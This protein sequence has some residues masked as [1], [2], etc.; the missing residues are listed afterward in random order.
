MAP[1]SSAATTSVQVALRI[2]PPTNQDSTSI[3]ARFQ[4]TVIHATSSTSVS[5]E[6]TSSTPAAGGAAAA[7]STAS[8]PGV[9]KQLFSFDQ[10]H[11][12]STTQH[13]LFTST[14]LPL[15]S[16]F[17]EGFNCTILAYGQTSSGKTF[18]MTGI[19]LD[20]NPS[21]PNNGMGI[22]PRAVSSIFAGARKLKEERGNTWNYSIKGSFIEIYNEDL[23]DLLSMDDGAGGRREVQIREDKDGHIIWGGLR[24][25]NVKNP[26]E[27]MT[28]IRKGTSIRRTNETDMNAQS[29]RSHAIFSLTLTQKKYSGSGAPPRSSSPLPPGG[30]SPSRLARPGSVYSGSGSGSTSGNRVGSPTFGRPATPSFA[31]AMGRGGGLRPSSALGHAGD[32]ASAGGDD[33]GGEWTTIVSKFHFVDLAGSER[34]KRTAAAGERIK[35]GISINSGLL[36]LGNVISALGDP[37]RAKS[38]TA[39]HI[40]YRDSKLTR[41]LQDSLGGNA[42]TLMIA[43]VSPAEWNTGETV[44]TLKYANRARNIKNRAVVNEKEDGWDDVEWLQGTVTRLRKEVKVLKS[45]GSISS[46]DDTAPVP[47]PVEG[48]GKKVLAQMTELQNN[49]EDLRAKF[50]ER[51]EEL[52]RLRRE[53]GEKHRGSSGAVSGTGK[54]EEIVGPVIEEYEKTIAAMEAELSLNRAAL[55]HTNEMVEEKEEELAAVT[56]RHTATELYVEE[57]RSRVAKLSEREASTEAYVRDLEEKMRAYD[58]TSISSS[59]SMSDLKREVA[60]YKEADTHS[61]KYIADLEVRLSRSDESVVSLQ[62]TVER[63]EKESEQRQEEVQI[64]QARLETLRQDGESWRSDLER[65]EAKVRELEIKMVEWEKKRQDAGDARVRLGTV[66]DEVA[67]ARRSFEIDLSTPGSSP[68]EYSESD[69]FSIAGPIL[70]GHSKG[71]SSIISSPDSPELPTTNPRLQQELIALQQTHNATLADLSSVTTKYRDA[72]REISDLA[73]QIQEAKLANTTGESVTDTTDSERA[74]ERP[75]VKRR[76]TSGRLRENSET[77]Y[78]TGGRRLFFRQAAST[79]SLHSRSLSQSQSLSQELSSARSRKHS[80]SSHGTASSHSPSNSH[81]ATMSPRPNL[82]ISLPNGIMNIAPAERSAVSLEKEIMRLQEVLKE[83]EAEISTLELS[84]LKATQT[85]SSASST[86]DRL[87]DL[88]LELLNGH[89]D[90]AAPESFLSPQTI[91]KFEHIRRSMQF[92]GENG[93]SPREHDSISASDSI[94]SDTDESLDRLNE[95]ML[96]MAQKESSHRE[97]V[98][99][100]TRELDQTRRSFEELTTLSRD[101]ALNMSTEVEALR[102]KHQ[103][104][105]RRLEEVQQRESELIETLSKVE[106]EHAAEVEEL[107]AYHSDAL[108]QKQEELEALLSRVKEEH[109]VALSILQDELAATS[110]ALEEALQSHEQAFGKLRQDHEE[111]LRSKLQEASDTLASVRREHESVLSK[112]N[113]AHAEALKQKDVDATASIQQTEEDYYNALTKLRSDNAETLVRHAAESTAAL[114]K[115]KEEHSAEMRM[116]ERAKESLLSKSQSSRGL[117]LQE[118]QNEHSSAITRK[119]STHTEDLEKLKAEHA[120]ALVDKDKGAEIEL[121]KLRAAM[122]RKET[123]F[124]EEFEKAKSEHA[125]ALSTL[126]AEHAAEISSTQDAHA[127]ILSST[128]KEHAATI[129]SIKGVHASQLDQI[130]AEHEEL[131][132]KLKEEQKAENERLNSALSSLENDS[133]AAAADARTAIDAAVQS[134]KEQQAALLENITRSHVDE[135]ELLQASHK[136]TTHDMAIASEEKVANLLESHTVEVL[137]LRAQH[138]QE[139]TELNGNIVALQEQHRDSLED[140]RALGERIVAET[141]Q[142]L[143]TTLEDLKAQHDMES[144]SL[145]K[146]NELLVQELEAHKVAADEFLLRDQTRQAYEEQITEKDD[147]IRTMGDRLSVAENERDEL[148]SDLAKLRAEVERTRTEQSFLIQEASKRESLVV[149]LERHRSVLA[150]LQENLQKVKDEKDTLQIEKSRSDTL[151]RELQAHIARSGSPPN[152]RPAPERFNRIPGAAGIK[153]PPPTPPPSVPPPPAP[154]SIQHDSGFSGSSAGTSSSSRDSQQ[155]PESPATP[156]T[157]LGGSII[158][159]MPNSAVPDGK[160]LVKIDEQAK[161]LEEQEAMIKTLN[162]Q[163]THCEGDLQTHMDLVSTLETSL[164]DSEKN[165]RKARMHA[166]ELARER[167]RLNGDIEALRKELTD[168]K[169]EVVNVRQSIVEEKQ[170]YEQRLDEERKAKERARQQLDSRMEELSKRKSKFACL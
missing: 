125:T 81:S 163:L 128:H 62:Q 87:R 127:S 153:L 146:E 160:A 118:L 166:T 135:L 24:E 27:V 63:L 126:Q 64:L 103:K 6:A 89:D 133:S 98:D 78:N 80:S 13:T 152:G 37:S 50:V 52:T 92:H 68:K 134:Q 32:R 124:T 77:Q 120:R 55:R 33:E 84:L 164:G 18:T 119:E 38:H 139:I 121:S 86:S 149:E 170:S 165:L 75:V 39:T 136:R 83:R 94:V 29:S 104:D 41:L 100:L 34:L 105:L 143:Q 147:T 67:A 115:L 8:G 97:I 91:N 95:L 71:D 20:A 60:R 53:L 157:S 161:Q 96:S 61:A 154:R 82:S 76:M 54:Y 130:R 101:Q 2:R 155:I 140:V 35:E 145:R 122:T 137:K 25:V 42:H 9:K 47:E 12:P 131:V 90:E 22:I 129:A 49:Y 168:T 40:P 10:V 123:A 113:G 3:P 31:A 58:E 21:D 111:E 14:A 156:A 88:K 138:Q 69:A 36:A 5:V 114:E 72:L 74:P 99:S 4:R 43:C 44:N 162:K 167:D 148:A 132:S 17:T 112:V 142:S 116:A 46:I 28:L 56:E 93:N 65:R 79:E 109:A 1:S 57:L 102:E 144:E 117:A 159:S 141:T 30:R 26:N 66:V 150:E 106:A 107:R 73:A 110:S 85:E 7:T 169:R 23:I 70:N 16:R 11:D 151:V 51:T 15:V 59:E 108:K 19:D 45:G 48:A 158:T